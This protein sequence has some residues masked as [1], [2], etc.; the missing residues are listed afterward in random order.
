MKKRTR[1][2]QYVG[3]FSASNVDDKK[4]L[5]K[6][7]AKLTARETD[8]LKKLAK[9]KGSWVLYEMLPQDNH[10]L[11][12]GL[13][14]EQLKAMLPAGTLPE[15]L[16]DG[17]PAAQ[18]DPKDRVRGGKYVRQL[19]DF[20]VLL[21]VE[22]KHR[23]LLTDSIEAAKTDKLL[24][25]KALADAQK[26][27]ESC[28]K[29]IAAAKKLLAKA[30]RQRDVVAGY[31]KLLEEKLAAMEKRV[32]NLIAS[33]R[34]MAGQIAKFQLEAAQRIDQRTRYG[35]IRRRKAIKAITGWE[36]TIATITVRSSGG[37]LR[38][39]TLPKPSSA[40]S[41]PSTPPSGSPIFSHR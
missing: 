19:R 11:F 35:P 25:D 2:G 16:K 21:S 6:P 7:T 10:E 41:S 32:A 40:G 28:K 37:P 8:R 31:R 24:L 20:G 38:F 36:S 3:E 1:K 39:P 5:L 34:A 9:G 13:T 22:Q 30:G 17:K 14:D 33:S 12:A 18:D 23:I 15:F 26:Q 29:D 27:E 4:I